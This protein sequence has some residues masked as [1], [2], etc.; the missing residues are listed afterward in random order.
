[1]LGQPAVLDGEDLR[2]L[3]DRLKGLKLPGMS[4]RNACLVG[5]DL[6]GI[7]LQ[8]ANLEGADLRGVDLRDADLRGARLSKA[9]L[10]R[11][12]LR[13]CQLGPLPWAGIDHCRQAWQEPSF[14]SCVLKE[15]C[16]RPPAWMVPK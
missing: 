12:D 11:A 3:S 14:A 16:L 8:G 4:A 10:N 9:V 2:P 15:P 5:L 6:R 13:G 7:G 1:M